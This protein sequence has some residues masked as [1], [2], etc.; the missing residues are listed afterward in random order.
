LVLRPRGVLFN[1]VTLTGRLASG[2][3]EGADMG[4]YYSVAARW[5]ADAML[6]GSETIL[7]GFAGQ[8]ELPAGETAPKELHPLAVP[9]LVV[10][11][12]RGRIHLWRLIRSQP[13]WRDVV[14]L[15]SRSTP[16]AYLKELD[17]AGVEW[18]VAGEERVDFATA[19]EELGA[20][21]GVRT[22]R[23]DSGGALNGVLLRAGLVDEISVLIAPAVAGGVSLRDLFISPDA[24]PPGHVVPLRL[25]HHERIA[26]NVLWLRYEVCR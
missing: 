23:V 22:V 19:L 16:R 7:T 15:C 4:L 26:D 1:A 11:D 5:N 17:Q 2:D 20:R 21:Y 3:V 8:S 18:I 14:V 13:Y 9:M 6:S 12:S 10:A 25:V 24:L